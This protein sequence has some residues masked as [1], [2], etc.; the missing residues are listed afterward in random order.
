M[1]CLRSLCISLSIVRETIDDTVQRIHLVTSS[2]TDSLGVFCLYHFPLL[3]SDTQ[4]HAFDCEHHGTWINSASRTKLML[5]GFKRE[6][7]QISRSHSFRNTSK[8][9]MLS[10]LKRRNNA[11]VC[12]TMLKTE[13]ASLTLPRSCFPGDPVP[14]GS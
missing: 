6:V 2:E 14:N 4:S 13:N 12:Q 11:V 8:A 7:F 5:S 9:E 10:S 1:A 3:V